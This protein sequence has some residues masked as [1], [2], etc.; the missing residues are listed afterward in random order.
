MAELLVAAVRSYHEELKAAEARR[1]DNPYYAGYNADLQHTVLGLGTS[2]YWA[3]NLHTKETAEYVARICN[4]AYRQGHAQARSDIQ[5][6]L[7]IKK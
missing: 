7:G 2:H 1:T 5:R 3:P 4:E 6:I